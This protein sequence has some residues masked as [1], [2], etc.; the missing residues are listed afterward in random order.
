MAQRYDMSRAIS[1]RQLAIGALICPACRRR[2]EDAAETCPHCGFTGQ[3]TAEMFSFAAPK[4]APVLDE[5]GAFGG[6]E[7]RKIRRRIARLRRRFRQ[8]H[9][10]VCVVDLPAE[11][12][13]RLFG[14]WLLNA[15]PAEAGDAE[16]A[17]AW[18]VLLVI[19]VGRQAASV[20]C[21]YALETFISDDLW[22]R[23]L[24]MAGETWED[25]NRGAAVIGFL[26]GIETELARAARR[27]ER[28]L[29]K[30]G[31]L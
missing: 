12:S 25:G 2:L 20:S 14:F 10:S 26:N 8:I 23:C 9:V 28:V 7:R 29:R 30:G 4:L 16:A 21:G 1:A 18:T 22:V 11:F 31:A 15:A 3:D 5:A 13:L 19:D 6:S 17:N 27:A 24:E